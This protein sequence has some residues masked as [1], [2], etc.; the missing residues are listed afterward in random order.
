CWAKRDMLAGG[1]QNFW[2]ALSRGQNCAAGH[3]RGVGTE[4]G[5]GPREI[6][7][8]R[9][10]FELLSQF[11]RF[12]LDSAIVAI[13]SEICRLVGDCV[14]AAQ[15]LAN[16]GKGLGHFARTL[17]PKHTAAGL[18][19]QFTEIVVTRMDV[20]PSRIIWSRGA[21]VGADGV[22]DDISFLGSV[23]CAL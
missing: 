15:F 13:R 18:L 4:R 14:A 22:D 8:A 21:V 16:F 5:Y 20:V 7:F 2:P 11:V 10:N 6:S 1:S 12:N 19:R 9:A 23:D 17:R 3:G